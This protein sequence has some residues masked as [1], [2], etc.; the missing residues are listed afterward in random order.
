[1]VRLLLNV[2]IRKE[3]RYIINVSSLNSEIKINLFQPIRSL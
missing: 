1:M 3:L 2:P